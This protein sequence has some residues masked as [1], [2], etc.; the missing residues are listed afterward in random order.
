MRY[1]RL[2]EIMKDLEELNDIMN[3]ISSSEGSFRYISDNL[4]R[5]MVESLLPYRDELETTLEG[6]GIVFKEDTEPSYCPS[7][8]VLEGM[9]HKPYCQALV[10]QYI[11]T[12]DTLRTTGVNE[13]MYQSMNQAAQDDSDE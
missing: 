5:I 4:R 7:C 13:M 10:D 6:I 8:G 11:T 3:A 1:N 12:V 2:R 9:E